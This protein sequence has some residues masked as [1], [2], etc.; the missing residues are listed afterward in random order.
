[1][2]TFLTKHY[3]NKGHQ[4]CGICDLSE[5][6]F[7]DGSVP[8]DSYYLILDYNSIIECTQLPQTGNLRNICNA[9]KKEK[10]Y[11]FCIASKHCYIGCIETKDIFTDTIHD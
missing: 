6:F 5:P 1:M 10:F 3:Q 11:N 4:N 7:Q 9:H 8:D 2:L